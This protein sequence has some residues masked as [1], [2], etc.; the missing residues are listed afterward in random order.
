MKPKT[1]RGSSVP[2][3][4]TLPRAT[5]APATSKTDISKKATGQ[6]AGIQSV[7]VARKRANAS[8]DISNVSLVGPFFVIMA[9]TS[10]LP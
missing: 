4:G 7:S 8:K 6:Y 9:L 5:A 3:A 10:E 1:T 2:G